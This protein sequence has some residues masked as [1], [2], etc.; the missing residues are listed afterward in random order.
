[1]CADDD[2][3]HLTCRF[4]Y[5]HR[6][7]YREKKTNLFK[8]LPPLSSTTVALV[9]II[10]ANKS[11]R[12]TTIMLLARTLK[13]VWCAT[14][15]HTQACTQRRTSACS[16]RRRVR[17]SQ[18]LWHRAGSCGRRPKRRP[19]Q[20]DARCS[21]QCKCEVRRLRYVAVTGGASVSLGHADA[22]G[23]CLFAMSLLVCRWCL[24]MSYVFML[25]TALGRGA[26][27]RGAAQMMTL[28]KPRV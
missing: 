8:H 28:V 12:P 25:R 27:W 26:E 18:V 10:Y 3:H 23:E 6:P 1:M 17:E 16:N 22:G 11:R 9:L 5:K 19:K 20:L 7:T 14:P 24:N 13:I 21:R 15:R 4:K 2:H